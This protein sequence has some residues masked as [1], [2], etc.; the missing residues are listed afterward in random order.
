MA[1]AAVVL[2]S[3]SK[4]YPL[5]DGSSLRAVD[6]VSLVIDPGARVGLMG[7]SGSGKSTLL[8]LLGAIDRP[9]SGR[10]RVGE[11]M[12]TG[13]PDRRLAD[14][15]ARVGFVFQQ[16]HLVAGLSLLDNVSAPLAGR[17]FNGDKRARAR[18]LLDAVGLGDRVRALPSQLSGGQQQRVA[19]ARAMVAHP[20]LLL[21]DE[22]TGNLDSSTAAEIMD[23]LTRLQAEFGTTVVL[24]THDQVVAA[25]CEVVYRI[26]DGVVADA[27]V[28]DVAA[29]LMPRRVAA[30]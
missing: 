2:E 9:D 19:I 26:S 12:I 7:A 6:D 27:E 1:G 14:Y 4:S 16:F 29:E 22:P 25:S 18:E 11:L 5:G 20:G 3:V 15:R 17:P 23:L 8:H 21:A 28:I 10:I 13:L 30:G 24:A